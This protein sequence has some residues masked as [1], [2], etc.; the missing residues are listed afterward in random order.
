[1]WI[2]RGLLSTMKEM[3]SMWFI[4]IPRP[5]SPQTILN[6]PGIS[7]PAFALMF[8]KPFNTSLLFRCCMAR[9][10]QARDKYP[11]FLP[12]FSQGQT[13][14]MNN[15]Y[16]PAAFLRDTH[17]FLLL[18]FALES[19]QHWRP[20]CG[21][22]TGNNSPKFKEVCT[23]SN[24]KCSPLTFITQAVSYPHFPIKHPLTNS[25]KGEVCTHESPHLGKWS[26]CS[27]L[28]SYKSRM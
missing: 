1:M 4:P 6:C 11:G 28:I 14:H 21:S 18:C 17:C 3:E 15:S 20:G 8:A 2:N 24:R 12:H 7:L 25:R 26:H 5:F 19:N 16:L 9:N 23:P 22:A 13:H 10:F 27:V